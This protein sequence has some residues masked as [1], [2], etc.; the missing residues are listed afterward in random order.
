MTQF[1][2]GSGNATTWAH[3][4]LK[5]CSAGFF[6]LSGQ[7]PH[8]ALGPCQRQSR[9]SLTLSGSQ[10]KPPAPAEASEGED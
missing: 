5:A 10:K 8:H 3:E 2:V 4:D 7:E 9:G 1:P 6:K